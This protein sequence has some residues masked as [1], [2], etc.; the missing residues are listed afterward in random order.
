MKIKGIL[1][2]VVSIVSIFLFGCS[3]EIKKPNISII[4]GSVET[5]LMSQLPPPKEVRITT[6]PIESGI[7]ITGTNTNILLSGKKLIYNQVFSIDIPK[8][9][10]TWTYEFN[11]RNKYTERLDLNGLEKFPSHIIISYQNI[12]DW[13]ANKSDKEKCTLE[14]YQ[15]DVGSQSTIMKKYGLK[16]VYVTHINFSGFDRER[17]Q[18]DICFL[19]DNKIYIVSVSEF[20]KSK[21]SDVLNSF[22]F[23]Q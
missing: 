5:G 11:E 10:R 22:K 7:N 14:R 15:E 23:L 12:P 6:M 13:S 19:K 2:L 17:K 20:P 4:T 16:A 1:I 21:I 9:I 8:E 3:T 18:G